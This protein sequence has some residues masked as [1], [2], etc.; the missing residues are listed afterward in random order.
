MIYSALFACLMAFAACGGD[1]DSPGGG[2]AAGQVSC[3]PTE[4]TFIANGGEQSVMVNANREWMAY[5]SADWITVS[6]KNSTEKTAT[7]TV[8]VAENGTY[9][10]REGTVTVKAGE[11]VIQSALA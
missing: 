11:T 4:L 2:N 1:D 6:P 8:K 5:A 9:D 10:D 3:S 7:L